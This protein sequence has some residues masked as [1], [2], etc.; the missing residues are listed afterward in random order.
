[1]EYVR[2]GSSGLQ[3]SRICLGMM[4]YGDRQWREWVLDE[5]HAEPI[6]R[7]AVEHGIIFFDTANVYSHG[8]SEEITGRPLSKFFARRDD[9][10]LATKVNSPMGPGPNDRGLSRKHILSA[11]DDSL[12]RLGTDYVDLYQVH[13]WNNETPIEESMEALHDL[14]WAGKVRYIGASSMSP[15]SS[16]KPS[17]LPSVMDGPSLSPCRTTTICCT[18]RKSER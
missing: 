11:L 2:L 5:A 9:Y 4:S 8:I 18:A 13:R 6:V 10:V 17:T 16:P 3:V 14:V 1:V 15:G 7:R 12:R